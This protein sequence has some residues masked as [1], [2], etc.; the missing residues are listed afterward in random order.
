MESSEKIKIYFR[1]KSLLNANTD[2]T[3]T[4]EIPESGRHSKRIQYEREMSFLII[5]IEKR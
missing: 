4:I 2:G 5:I 1:D 3:R